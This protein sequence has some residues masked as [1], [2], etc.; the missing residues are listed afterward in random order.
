MPFP[1]GLNS[2]PLVAASLPHV[3][4]LSPGIPGVTSKLNSLHLNPDL[5]VCFWGK[6]AQGIAMHLCTHMNTCSCVLSC[7]PYPCSLMS[8]C[9]S[10]GTHHRRVSWGCDPPSRS[11]L[12]RLRPVFSLLKWNSADD[13][14]KNRPLWLERV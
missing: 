14:C 12:F 11:C 3:P 8:T 9:H 5:E 13:K 6:P 1:L 10:S 7:S 4:L 2:R